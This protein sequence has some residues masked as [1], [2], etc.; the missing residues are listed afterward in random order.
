[1]IFTEYDELM[2]NFMEVMQNAYYNRS[3]TFLTDFFQGETKVL[4]CIKRICDNGRECTPGFISSELGLSTARTASIL[5]SL[6]HKGYIGRI[7]AKKDK[8]R[9]IVSMTEEGRT[10]ADEKHREVMA[11][12]DK[13]FHAMGEKDLSE[14]VRLIGRLSEITE[15]VIKE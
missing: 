8:R 10:F 1:M 7:N 4:F 9:V 2:K 14:L 13:A 3:I 15:N 11:F 12:Y 6:E 5:R